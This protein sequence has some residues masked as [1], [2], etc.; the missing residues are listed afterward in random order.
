MR[1]GGT[2]NG[3]AGDYRRFPSAGGPRGGATSSSGSFCYVGSSAP[4]QAI[5]EDAPGYGKVTVTEDRAGIVILSLSDG[6]VSAVGMLPL[7]A[8]V[9]WLTQHP[10][11]GH[12][13]CV[14]GND[15][16][17]MR[18]NADGTLSPPFST[19]DTGGGSAVSPFPPSRPHTWRSLDPLPVP[20]G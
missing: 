6:A 7:D 11:N 18:I 16:H 5:T 19:A 3:Q 1:L 17:A 4:G 20:G 10:T 14:S 9:G 12:L 15:A 13:Y 2:S 8:H